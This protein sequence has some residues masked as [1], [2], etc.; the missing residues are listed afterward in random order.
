MRTELL[1]K[2]GNISQIAGIRESEILR[3][4]GEGI[5]IAEVYNAAGLRFTVVPD[6][7]MDLFDL[8][9]K[10]VNLCFQ[11]KNGMI[12]PQSFSSQDGDFSEQWPGGALVTC[13][14]DNVGGHCQ[15]GSIYP[16]HGRFAFL[17]AQTFGTECCWQGD[18][19]L[20]QLTGEVH[21]T[22]MYGRHLSVHRT[23]TTGL[24]SRSIRIS[25]RITNFEPEDEPLMLLYHCN[26]GYPLL[27]KDA[28]TAVNAG[29]TIPLNERS[30]DPVHMTEPIDGQEEE[31]YLHTTF[32]EKGYGVIYNRRLALGAYVSFSTG[33]LPNMMQWKMM[34]S[35]DYV[36]AFEPCNTWGLNRLEAGQQQKLAR[37]AGYSQIENELEIGVLDGD[38]EL[39]RFMEKIR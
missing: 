39:N 10:G 14:L 18:D 26:F 11:S 7:G 19:Y 20:L 2:L 3:G 1:K 17:P 25:D 33:Y 9:Y 31:L 28:V 5:K 15:E 16:A 35:H 23:I 13:G 34:K 30:A 4:P 6:M 37:I 32:P 29:K 36:M 8:S 12:A 21:Q 38:D 24:D 27:D 22:R